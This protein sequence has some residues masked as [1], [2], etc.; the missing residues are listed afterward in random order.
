VTNSRDPAGLGQARNRLS[1]AVA[2]IAARFEQKGKEL[3]RPFVVKG[4]EL[5]TNVERANRIRWF[6]RGCMFGPRRWR[7]ADRRIAHRGPTRGTRSRRRVSSN[8]RRA[9]APGRSTDDDGESSR[10]VARPAVVLRQEAA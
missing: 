7:L 1:A 9:R 6:V 5:I 4:R 10:A 2:P 3:H 8:P